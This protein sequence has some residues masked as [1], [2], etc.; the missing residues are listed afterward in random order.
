ME[1]IKKLLLLVLGCAVQVG[2]RPGQGGGGP[3]LSHPE[4]GVKLPQ[5]S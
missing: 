4:G 1:E 3:A 5:G 2:A